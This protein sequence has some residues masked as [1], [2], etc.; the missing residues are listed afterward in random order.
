MSDKIA[1]ISDISSFDAYHPEANATITV[2]LEA[3]EHDFLIIDSNES[4]TFD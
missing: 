2:T 4:V 3:D 1:W